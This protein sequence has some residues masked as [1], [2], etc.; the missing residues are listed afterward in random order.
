M[1]ISRFIFACR[2]LGLKRWVGITLLAT[3]LLSTLF[4]GIGIG[5]ILPI[6]DFLERG[7]DLEALSDNSGLWSVLVE[8]YTFLGVDI[9]LPTLLGAALLFLAISIGFTYVRT[10]F[11]AKANMGLLREVRDRLFKH[12]L[13]VKLSYSTNNT[14]SC[15]CRLGRVCYKRFY[16][17]I[18]T[19]IWVAFSSIVS[20]GF[21]N[22]N[23]CLFRISTCSVGA[24]DIGHPS[25]YGHFYA[26]CSGN[27]STL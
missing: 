10:V 12:N 2:L 20:S 23:F 24:D 8:V 5:M 19:S 9:T 11:T 7:G 16:N 13:N 21:Y 4:E 26:E 18:R 25:S 17:R 27:D 1:T 22:F 6:M 3:H 14:P 15:R